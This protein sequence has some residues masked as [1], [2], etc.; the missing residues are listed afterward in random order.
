MDYKYIEQLL[1]RYFDCLTTLE[2]EQILRSFFCQEDVPAYL[3]QYRSIFTYQAE[4]KNESLDNDFDARI[5]SEIEKVEK[6]QAKRSYSIRRHLSPLFRAAAIVVVV[7]S[8]GNIAEHSIYNMPIEQK[9]D[10]T[11]INPYIKSS[12]IN[13]AVQIKDVNS[14]QATLPNDSLPTIQT[15]NSQEIQ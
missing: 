14:A 13:S 3:M 8:I 5:L 1:D 4:A 12:D 7:L 2:E 9:S 10:A 15:E 11:A 6:K